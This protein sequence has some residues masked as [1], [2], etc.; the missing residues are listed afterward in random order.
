[1]ALPSLNTQQVRKIE[2]LIFGWR[3]K[4]SWDVLVQRIESDFGIET[5]RQTLNTYKP[6][7]DAFRDKK[8]EL[9]G[10]PTKEFIQFTKAEVNAYER[11]KSLES[12]V[13]SLEKKVDKQKAFIQLIADT[14]KS[15][16]LLL[17]VLNKTKLLLSR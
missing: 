9:R 5:T 4:L 1:M 17:E 13:T 3:T 2:K 8:Q 15:N 12:E 6:I 10:A 14:A 7:K 11:I 16:P